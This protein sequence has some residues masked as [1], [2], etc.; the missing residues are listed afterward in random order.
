MN[1][2]TQAR[3]IY[4]ASSVTT[5]T[6]RNIEFS[7]LAKVTGALHQATQNKSKDFPKFV[8]ALNDNRTLWSIFVD[9]LYDPENGLDQSLRVQL[10][11][12]GLFVQKHTSNVL[13]A[14]ASVTPLLEIN[15]AILRGLKDGPK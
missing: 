15:A 3:K 6:S 5:K 4:A 11:E 13:S 2:H 9:D 8:Q 7:V 1:A 10:I 12:L 14:K